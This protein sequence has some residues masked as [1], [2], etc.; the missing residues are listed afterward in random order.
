MYV[1]PGMGITDTAHPST[2]MNL[3][4]AYSSG[5]LV[6][7]LFGVVLVA[8]LIL[9]FWKRGPSKAELASEPA[10]ER[11]LTAYGQPTQPASRTQPVATASHSPVAGRGRP[12]WAAPV[13]WSLAALAA[14]VIIVSHKDSNALSSA[15]KNDFIRGCDATAQGRVDCGCLLNQLIDKGYDTK[16]EME[17]LLGQIRDAVAANSPASLPADYV[18]S[19]RSCLKQ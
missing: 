14:I 15:Y 6:G 1:V 18:A 10:P 12:G 17:T 7:K 19:A 2:I 9:H 5:Q 13:V 8:A 11:T 16:T 4:S 3:A